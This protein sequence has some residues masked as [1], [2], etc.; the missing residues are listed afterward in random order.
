MCLHNSDRG[1][2]KRQILQ[3]VQQGIDKTVA[4]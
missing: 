1:D 4:K 3:I 2:F